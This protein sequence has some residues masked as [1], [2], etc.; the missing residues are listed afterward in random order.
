[1][2]IK[3]KFERS[4]IRFLI[5]STSNF[6]LIKYSYAREDEYIFKTLRILEES[7]YHVL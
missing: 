6:S 3:V 5:I 4:L 1:M 7:F 2:F